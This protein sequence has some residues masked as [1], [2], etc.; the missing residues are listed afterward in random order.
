MQKTFQIL[1]NSYDRSNVEATA[2]A[3]KKLAKKLGVSADETTVDPAD[4]PKFW[5]CDKKDVRS[6]SLLVQ[7]TIEQLEELVSIKSPIG[8]QIETLSRKIA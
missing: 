6:A 5:G 7:C 8:V 4:L 2:L 3:I 1:L